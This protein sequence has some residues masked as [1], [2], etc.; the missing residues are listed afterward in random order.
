M[1]RLI[2]GQGLSARVSFASWGMFNNFWRHFWLSRLGWVGQWHLVGGDHGDAECPTVHWTMP[3]SKKYPAQMAV[4]PRQEILLQAHGKEAMSGLAGERVGFV[5]AH[6]G[7]LGIAERL[8][9]EHRDLKRCS[10]EEL[11]RK[12]R[13]TWSKIIKSII[14]IKTPNL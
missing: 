9:C 10:P 4:M 8:L 6:K 13:Y 7:S 14:I 3:P 5:S 2:L 1:Q 11:E 12:R